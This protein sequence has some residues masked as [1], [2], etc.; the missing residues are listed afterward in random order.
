M[1]PCVYRE[2][3]MARDLSLEIRTSFE[4]HLDDCLEC[5]E[6]I[7][8]W[9][10]IEEPFVMWRNECMKTAPT[11]NN[12]ARLVER[13]RERRTPPRVR[14]LA[15]A[16]AV[17]AMAMGIAFFVDWQGSK[18]EKA[19]QTGP[20][21]VVAERSSSHG[22]DRIEIGDPVGKLLDVPVGERMLARLGKDRVGLDSQTSVRILEL[23]QKVARL[24][25]TKG[26]VACQVSRR[27]KGGE[28]QVEAGEFVVRV[29][30]TRFSVAMAEKSEIEVQVAEGT[31]D[32][33]GPGVE[34]IEVRAGQGVK[35]P[36][37][38]RVELAQVTPHVVEQIDSLLSEI[39]LA[40]EPDPEVAPQETPEP[41][42]RE[43]RDAGAHSRKSIHGAAAK[44][45]RD[46]DDLKTWRRWIIEGRH[47]EAERALEA[48]LDRSP[49]DGQAWMLLADLRR[50][51]NRW[52]S[53]VESYRRAAELSGFNQARFMAG[54][55]LQD[56][57]GDDQGAVDML[58]EY[59]RPSS[60]RTALRAEAMVRL[61]RS[62]LRLG[63]RDR[64]KKL[65][66]EVVDRSGAPISAKARGML[67][68][69]EGP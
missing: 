62:Y 8:R 65:L 17:V 28:F 29:L 52:R 1:K 44:H 21:P 32:V 38:G 53:A 11:R 43:R 41:R 24:R 48:H 36:A 37:R 33:H 45:T 12:A 31:V 49:T 30:G 9:R 68:K 54:S 51:G 7:E 26:K 64:A 57:L 46:G 34:G 16:A 47:M 13:F 23:D 59:I 56:K 27:E 22:L 63:R 25:L 4:A 15:W 50:R 35:I 19:F 55:I 42:A 14:P 39:A 60:G 20:P 40:G 66:Q 2:E 61:A 3:Y 18:T 5:R 58:E 6:L 67:E 69:I 10:A